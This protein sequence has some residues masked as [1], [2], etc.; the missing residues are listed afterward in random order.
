MPAK[1]QKSIQQLPG[2]GAQILPITKCFPSRFSLSVPPLPQLRRVS[3]FHNESCVG[4]AHAYAWR[5]LELPS[6]ISCNGVTLSLQPAA[7]IRE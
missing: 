3:P 1:K 5:S 6:R 2:I 7:H 4:R